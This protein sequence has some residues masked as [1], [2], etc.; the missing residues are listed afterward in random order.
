MASLASRTIE[1]EIN[2]LGPMDSMPYF[3]AQDH[4]RDNLALES[5]RVM[6]ADAR[7][8]GFALERDGFELVPHA[9][10]V[11]DFN[12]AEE[13]RELYTAE[14]ETLI[15]A[16]T[17]ADHVVVTPGGVLRFSTRTPR[18]ELVNSLPAGFAHIDYSRAAFDAFAAR[19]LADHPDGEAL[20]GGRYAAYNIWRV[21]TAPPQDMPLTVCAAPS[22]AD[23][24]RIEGEARIDGDGID[25]IRFGS[26][27]I[28]PNPAHRW[29]WFSGMTPDEALIFKAFDSDLERVQGCPHTAFQ[30]PDPDANPRSSIETRAFAYWRD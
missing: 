3:Y 8:R 7:G 21:L 5:H 1:A 30:N 9:S 10:A 19:N 22:M 23:S 24:D 13:V 14:I 29:Y 27:L 26:S 17:G 16:V 11:A 4:E 18:P 28:R 20:R 12:D 2:Y 15:H 25:E 6:I